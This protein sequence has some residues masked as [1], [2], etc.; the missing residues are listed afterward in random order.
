MVNQYSFLPVER[1]G[2]HLQWYGI[3]PTLYI[4]PDWRS[5]AA[6]TAVV[7]EAATRRRR[8]REQAIEHG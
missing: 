7:A 5:T 2:T 3:V 4:W 8:R 1:R 6:A